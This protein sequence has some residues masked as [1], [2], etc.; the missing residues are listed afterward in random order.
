MV[1]SMEMHE[2]DSGVAWLWPV[3]QIVL[4]VH[5]EMLMGE[6]VF[7]MMELSWWY[8]IDKDNVVV[9]VKDDIIAVADVGMVVE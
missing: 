1:E 2:H 3:H 5:Q 4:S 7:E 8:G 6:F 9:S